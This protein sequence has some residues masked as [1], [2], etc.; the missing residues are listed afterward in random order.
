MQ[1]IER[2]GV[3]ALLFLVVTVV[4]VMLWGND[5]ESGPRKK[6]QDARPA[7]TSSL[8]GNG[9]DGALVAAVTTAQKSRPLIDERPITAPIATEYPRED[10][11]GNRQS[12]SGSMNAGLQ[13]DDSNLSPERTSFLENER[14]L[15]LPSAGG[16]GLPIDAEATYPSVDPRPAGDRLNL[17]VVKHGD[18]LSTI[19]ERELGSVRH[20]QKIIDLNPGLNKD[21]IRE[22][23]SLRLPVIDPSEA[24]T[25][26]AVAQAP[27]AD[28]A[29]VPKTASPARPAA[30]PAGTRSYVVK[31]N[32]NLWSI[33]Q[34]QLGA[35]A[36][37]KEIEALNPGLDPTKIEV[38]KSIL[39]P[40]GAD[41][42]VAQARPQ[43]TDS[44]SSGSQR[45]RVR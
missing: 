44:S 12:E 33:A 31:P 2:Y 16:A 19:A 10:R 25:Q 3:V 24:A 14:G 36:R 32:D 43:K 17:Y 20:M 4:T 13:V 15:L 1:S 37:W 39:L 42:I 40:N 8:R 35:G 27:A 23:I 26:L 9:R 21:R 28:T 38:G 6:P 18:V 41:L 5:E 7:A 22:G 29:A 34:V 30:A 45:G 11:F